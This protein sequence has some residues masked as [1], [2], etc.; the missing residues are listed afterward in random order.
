M[1]RAIVLAA[2]LIWA[3]GCDHGE[4]GPRPPT[5]DTT[6]PAAVTDLAADNPTAASIT[7]SWTAPG[8]DGN[9]G[10]A[11]IY[12]VRYSSR[13]ITGENWASATQALGEPAPHIAGT[14]ETMAVTGLQGSTNYYFA[15]VACDEVPN[16]APLS[17]VPS[18]STTAAGCPIIVSSPNGGESWPV[19]STQTIRWS[20]SG[21]CGST[22]KIELLREGA[23]CRTVADGVANSGSYTWSPAWQC[24][25]YTDGYK[26][27]VT[28]WD[29]GVSDESDTTFVIPDGACSVLMVSPNGGEWWPADSRQTIR[30]EHSANCGATVLLELLRGSVCRTI[31]S[32]VPNNGSYTWD[33]VERCEMFTKDDYSIRVTDLT[34]GASDESNTTFTMAAPPCVLT[35]TSPNG[36]ESWMAGTS[37][38]ITWTGS[39][40]CGPTVYVDLYRAGAYCT[41]LGGGVG[42]TGSFTWS[43]VRPYCGFTD[44]Y[45]IRVTDSYVYSSDASDGT[46]SIL[47]SDC[48]LTVTSPN[49]GESWQVGSRQTITWNTSG[50]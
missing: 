11:S 7:L 39:G 44:G 45:E 17:N 26:I 25:L 47:P 46:F 16:C 15:I 37:H 22:V 50:T 8:D 27:R 21:A 18:A 13:L 38:T 3:A 32:R 6:P 2:L 4:S 34:T 48:S 41:T 28:D 33:P 30:W 10:T 23:V 20:A 49:G 40:T 9:S 29:T 1:S 31:A 35:V 43:V 14:H 36:G 12:D 19:G 42:N 5:G 24:D